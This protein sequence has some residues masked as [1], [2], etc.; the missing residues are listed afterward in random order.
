MC[1][2]DPLFDN[3]RL[4]LKMPQITQTPLV[5]FFMP[6][7]TNRNM[8]LHMYLRGSVVGYE[9]VSHETPARVTY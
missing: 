4:T 9:N 3:T 8:Y 7:H 2:A 1:T 5:G 6:L